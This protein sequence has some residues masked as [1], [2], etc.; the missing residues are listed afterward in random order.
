[1]ALLHGGS[2]KERALLDIANQKLPI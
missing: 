1:M 2:L